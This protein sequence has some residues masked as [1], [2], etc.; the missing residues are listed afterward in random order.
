MLRFI[1]V[2]AFMMGSHGASASA[3]TTQPARPNIVV[4]LADDLSVK[5]TSPYGNTDL[6]TPNMAAL[7]KEGLTFDR[8]YVNS[9]S[10]A[11]SR[12]ALLTGRYNVTNGVM[13]NHQRIKPEMKKWPAHFQSLG[14]EVVAIGKVSHY[15]HV[16]QLGFD[17][18][19]FFT[20]HEDVCVDEAVKWL[21]A[22]KAD[23]NRSGK[24]L[25][26]FVGTNWPHVPWPQAT[27]FEP[28]NMVLPAKNADT[29]RTRE[30]RTRY[31]A[32]VRRADTDLGKVRAAAREH[33][34]GDTLFVFT[35]DHGSQ[36]PFAKWNLYEA[37]LR[38]PL[39]VA[40]P[41][42]I[43]ADRRTNAM[44]SWLD[45]LP[46]LLDAAGAEVKTV[47]PD[48]DGR[49]FLPVL[50][51]TADV[52]HDR[53]FA[54]HSGDGN[55]NYYP[56]RSVRLGDI[57]Y[58][59]NLDPSLE[60]HTHVDLKQADT[61]Y[62]GSWTEAAKTDASIGKILDAY[63]RRPAEELYDLSIDPDELNNL[64]AD[65]TRAED[66][67]KA[68]VALDEWMAAHGDKGIKTDEAVRPRAETP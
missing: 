37:G 29:P 55:V 25:C 54:T 33:L 31:A 67:A 43:A 20:Y 36:F 24:P 15:G 18:A 40:W 13:F 12:A 4:F 61:G 44:V 46:T 8:A 6:A 45:L 48:L 47:A 7:A 21:S 62:F 38:T 5:D 60:F 10:C 35:A 41:G 59:R 16:Q 57:K 42:K 58:I 1:A 11:P 23:E 30:A 14:Y 68:R 34:T 66:L 52:A 26:I 19:A 63:Y 27:R 22:R 28:A 3:Q 9:P 49:S 17:H 65:A 53:V 32:A 56:S 2:I 39:I 51:G 50:A 64:A